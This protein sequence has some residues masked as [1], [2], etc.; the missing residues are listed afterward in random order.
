L[1]TKV[2]LDDDF[3]L[4]Q[5]VSN[6][7]LPIAAI[8]T[9]EIIDSLVFAEPIYNSSFPYS[10]EQIYGE[11]F[12]G[13]VITDPEGKMFQMNKLLMTNLNVAPGSSG[14]AIFIK[15]GEDYFVISS[16]TGIMAPEEGGFGYLGFLPQPEKLLE[17]LAQ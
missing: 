13:H 16:I 7:K 12:L 5:F 17:F 11:G 3:A 8:A 15:R 4:L 6:D 9:Q 14:S 10:V 1:V 2:D